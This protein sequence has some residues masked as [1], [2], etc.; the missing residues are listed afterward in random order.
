MSKAMVY[1]FIVIQDEIVLCV[2]EL[3]LFV[4]LTLRSEKCNFRP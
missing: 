1:Y 3:R 4:K 2:V